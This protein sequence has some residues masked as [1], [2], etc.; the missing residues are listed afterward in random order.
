MGD[1]LLKQVAQRLI[2]VVGDK[3][4]ICRL[5]G[6]EFIVLLSE[7]PM[8]ADAAVSQVASSII[9][10]LSAPIPIGDITCRIGVSI[11]CAIGDGG[12]SPEGLLLQADHLMYQA[13]AQGRGRYV[14]GHAN[15]MQPGRTVPLT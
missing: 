2:K 14:M 10:T 12:A 15:A 13:K 3:D 5:G 9:E 4:R 1:T 8:P 11:G 6:D 7:L